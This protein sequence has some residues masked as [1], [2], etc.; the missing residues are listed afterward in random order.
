MKVKEL[1]SILEK[2]PPDMEV[3][4][5]T[6]ENDYPV[7]QDQSPLIKEKVKIPNYYFNGSLQPFDAV[8]I[9]SGSKRAYT[10]VEELDGT[11]ICPTL[12]DAKGWVFGTDR[13]H[14]VAKFTD[15]NHVKAV[16]KV[17][18]MHIVA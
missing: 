10:V 5:R 18:G 13:E 17:L 11:Y 8:I 12:R 1:I 9:C 7:F 14:P 15:E 2:E 6:M 4:F 3:I 16:A